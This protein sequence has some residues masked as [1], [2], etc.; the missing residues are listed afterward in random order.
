MGVSN[1]K[2]RNINAIN[3]NEYF[4]LKDY[5]NHT[6]EVIRIF[7]GIGFLTPC[8]KMIVDFDLINVLKPILS[9]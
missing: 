9:S 2:A 5:F 1:E 8:P 3:V 4:I 7:T 6:Y